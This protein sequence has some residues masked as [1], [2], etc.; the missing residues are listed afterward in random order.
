MRRTP[1]STWLLAAMALAAPAL[2]GCATTE[3]PSPDRRDEMGNIAPEPK[4]Y[5]VYPGTLTGGSLDNPSPPPPDRIWQWNVEA[6][7]VQS[8]IPGASVPL[9]GGLRTTVA[10][11]GGLLGRAETYNVEESKPAAILVGFTRWPEGATTATADPMW[12]N[13]EVRVDWLLSLHPKGS[14][15]VDVEAMPRLM[16]PSGCTALLEEYRIRRT[17][18]LG[19][20]L[21]IAT[22]GNGTSTRV[23]DALVGAHDGKPARFVLRFK[24]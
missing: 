24:P 6:G 14:C 18:P 23:A 11:D 21:V 5:R 10:E 22:G 13:V 17:V 3:G 20:A 15:A 19:E 1:L 9:V 7:T 2:A 8:G 16:L 4:P 12:T